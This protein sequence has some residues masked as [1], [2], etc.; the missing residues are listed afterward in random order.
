[1]INNEE[2]SE[3]WFKLHSF[4]DINFEYLREV[5]INFQKSGCT[6]KSDSITYL[7]NLLNI[8]KQV[9][10]TDKEMKCLEHEFKKLKNTHFFY[11][12]LHNLVNFKLGKPIHGYN[13]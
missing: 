5:L 11:F 10:I 4:E 6:C 7:C 8:P 2:F 13:Y 12:F 3:I 9:C 1:M